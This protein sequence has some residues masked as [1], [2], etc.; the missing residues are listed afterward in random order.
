MPASEPTGRCAVDPESRRLVAWTCAT[1]AA[2][3]AVVVDELQESGAPMFLALGL[4]FAAIVTAAAI[5][6]VHTAQGRPEADSAKLYLWSY[7]ASALLSASAAG[8]AIAALAL[9]VSP[10][11]SPLLSKITIPALVALAM[12]D[13]YQVL[14]ALRIRDGQ[15]QARIATDDPVRATMVV[16]LAASALASIGAAAGL[17][18]AVEFSLPSALLAAGLVIVLALGIASVFLGL[19]FGERLAGTSASEETERS[20]LRALDRAGMRTG[21]IRAIS[22]VD[23]HYIGPRRLRVVVRIDFKDGVS[24]L[25]IGPVLETL[26]LAVAADVPEVVDVVLAPPLSQSQSR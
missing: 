23:A 21:A 8:A 16:V 20:V 6:F 4:M 2:V 17:V 1:H 24:A 26:K 25:H 22:G 15:A 7:G 18:L 19:H 12:F 13:L 5:L 3:L 9:V 10:E 11:Q 14:E